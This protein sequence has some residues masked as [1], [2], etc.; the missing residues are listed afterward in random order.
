M[1]SKYCLKLT[2]NID[3]TLITIIELRLELIY[4]GYRIFIVYFCCFTALKRRLREDMRAVAMAKA[5]SE[6]V[7]LITGFLSSANEPRMLMFFFFEHT[8]HGI[9]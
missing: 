7:C 3:I 6:R 1:L 5:L 9:N 8:R 4:T 2:K